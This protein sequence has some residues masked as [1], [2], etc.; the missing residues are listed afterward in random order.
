VL[1][2]NKSERGKKKLADKW[3]P[4]VYTVKDRNLQTI[5]YKLIDKEGKSKVVHRNLILDI[6][7]LPIEPPRDKDIQSDAD[8]MES[9]SCVS[10]LT[11]SLEEESSD[12]R[13]R[14]WVLEGEEQIEGQKFVDEDVLESD[15]SVDSR[16]SVCEQNPSENEAIGGSDRV[17]SIETESFANNPDSL[18][19]TVNDTSDNSITDTQHNADR[20]LWSE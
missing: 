11:D 9:E 4:T 10:D 20:V 17:P 7:F 13:T 12:E 19:E 3:D 18:T 1:L 14:A 8:N 16:R 2:A 15:N 5:I 6:S